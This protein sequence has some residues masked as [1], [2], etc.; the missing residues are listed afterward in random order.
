MKNKIFLG[1]CLEVLKTL[2]DDSLDASV[3]DPPYGLGTREPTGEEIIA[4]L[5][6]ETLDTG[7]DFMQRR[8]TIPS[9]AVWREVY[10]V[11]KPGAHL[12]VFAGT[13]TWDLISIGIRAAGFE[14]RD[15]VASQFGVQAF[16]WVQGCLT[17]D[18]EILTESGWRLGLDVKA[19][20]LV[21]AWDPKTEVI[22]LEP[23]EEHYVYPWDGELVV[24]RNDDTDQLLTPGH[25]VFHRPPHETG[26]WRCSSAGE[27]GSMVFEVPILRLGL[28]GRDRASATISSVGRE[29]YKGDVWCVKVSTGAFVARR[30][31]RMFCTGNSGFPKSRDPLK[32]EILPEI[33]RQ[34]RAQGVEGDIVWK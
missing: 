6:G 9:V 23:V 19:G 5:Q 7:G 29:H 18:A 2:P 14:F 13:R 17:A 10:R 24:L 31:D 12:V 34:L 3:V 1:D 15:T 4:Y 28:V 8:W 22:S 27:L 16:Q 21:A 26:P 33:E 11:L 30:N 20:E 25:R 32:N